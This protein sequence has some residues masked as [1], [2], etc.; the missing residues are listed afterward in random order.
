MTVGRGR[1][2]GDRA[3]RVL[4]S[5]MISLRTKDEVTLPASNRLLAE[6][7]TPLEL[8][9]LPE[10]RIAALIYPAGFYRTKAGN[11]RAVGKE[12]VSRFGGT[13]PSTLDEL[14][15]LPG[16]GRKTANLVLS[17]GLGIDAICVDTHV[18]RIANRIGWVAT[19]K[20]EQTE[21][22]LM[23]ILPRKYWIPINELLVGFGQ[24]TCTPISPHCSRCPVL[25]ECNRV[26]VSRSR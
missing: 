23:D 1:A 2:D 14:T 19:T 11:L 18:H 7:A 17:V 9:Q 16:V 21:Y 13:V 15:S 20:P 22:A 8:S 4:V 6:A 25:G 12:L 26:G 3:Y 24:Q 5:T 10:H